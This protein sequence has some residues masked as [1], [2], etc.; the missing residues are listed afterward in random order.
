MVTAKD[1]LLTPGTDSGLEVLLQ[2]AQVGI[3]G[4]Q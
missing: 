4:S 3:I 1:Q 2:V